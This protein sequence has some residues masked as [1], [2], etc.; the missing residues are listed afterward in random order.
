MLDI[1]KIRK[2]FSILNGKNNGLSPIYFDSA[3]M[4]LKPNQVINAINDYYLNY[5][6]CAG[7]SSHKLGNIVTKKV[8]ETRQRIAKFINA[9]NENEIIFTRN[10]TEGI[11]LFANSIGLKEGDIVLISDKEHNSN[12]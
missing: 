5:P 6:A 12:L 11:N 1:E 10:T 9:N 4:S 8:K 2:D 3:C 7:R